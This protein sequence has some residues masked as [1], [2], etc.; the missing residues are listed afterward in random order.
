MHTGVH[1]FLAFELLVNHAWY[2]DA[3]LH[4]TTNIKHTETPR[5][6]NTCK[7]TLLAQ[8]LWCVLSV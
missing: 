8:D 4:K 3:Y 7:C 2:D 6:V 1:R 5:L